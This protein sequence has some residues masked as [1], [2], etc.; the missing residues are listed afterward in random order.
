MHLSIDEA[1][2]VLGLSN[3]PDNIS[4]LKR[5]WRKVIKTVHPDSVES[6]NN[7]ELSDEYSRR[8]K[9]VNEALYTL[10]KV[11]DSNTNT[12]DNSNKKD[13]EDIPKHNTYVID[14]DTLIDVYSGK[15]MTSKDGVIIDRNLIINNKIILN[16]PIFYIYNNKKYTVDGHV[17]YN[18]KDEYNLYLDILKDKSS[19]TIDVNVNNKLISLN[20]SSN[21]ISINYKFSYGIK[22]NVNIRIR[23]E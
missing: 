23:E 15:E 11:L 13:K 1:L 12:Y 17:S 16:I 8:T 6:L 7:K 14:L 2:K 20:I 18:N 22:V 3:L 9:D 10:M 19:D 21:N 5:A 4:D